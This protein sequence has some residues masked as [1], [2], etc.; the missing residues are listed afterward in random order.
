MRIMRTLILALFLVLTAAI[1]NQ[2]SAQSGDGGV[3]TTPATQSVSDELR[4]CSQMLD[5][6]IAEVRALKAKVAAL[7]Q[8]NGLNG[9]I[10][11]KKDET[12]ADQAKLIGIYEKRKGLRV[13]F[14]FGLIKVSKN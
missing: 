5:Q 11:V 2:I 1:G 8:L 13:S 6:S 9:Q 14:L 12:I 7:E 4:D 3:R 10:I